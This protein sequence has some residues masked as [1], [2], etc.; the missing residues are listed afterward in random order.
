MVLRFQISEE[1]GDSCGRGHSISST[2]ASVESALCSA[3]EIEAGEIVVTVLG[4]YVIL[5]GFVRR[6][7]DVERAN[8]IAENIVGKGYVQ[9]R[10]LHR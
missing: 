8:Q 7:G 3:H 2:R 9:S 10:I 4:P 5:E 1:H 6:K